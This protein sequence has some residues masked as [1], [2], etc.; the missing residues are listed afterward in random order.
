MKD[1]G[2]GCGTWKTRTMT[3]TTQTHTQYCLVKGKSAWD[4]ACS[5]LDG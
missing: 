5:D 4:M 1:S 2:T 3:M